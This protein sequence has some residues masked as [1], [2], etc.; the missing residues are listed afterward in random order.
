MMK[1]SSFSGLILV[2][3]IIFFCC[4]Y[5]LITQFEKKELAEGDVIKF[6]EQDKSF[7]ITAIGDIMMHNTQISA[8]FNY[9]EKTYDFAS[10]FTYVKPIF[11]ASD[12][13]IGNLETTLAGETA[14]YSGYPRFNAP[15]VLADDL[16]ASGVDI[17]TTANNHCLDRNFPGISATLDHLDQVGLLHTGTSR[18]QEEQEKILLTEVKGVK[19]AVLAYTYGTNN[20]KV[21]KGK[22]FAVNYIDEKK[23][24]SDIAK[25][26]EQ[27]AKLVIIALHCGQEYQSYPNSLQKQLSQALLEAGADIILGHHPHVLQPADILEVKNEDSCE[28]KFVIYSLGNFISAQRGL[29]RRCSIILNLHMDVDEHGQPYFKEATYIPIYTRRYRNNGHISFEVL[30]LEPVLTS[31]KNGTNP[32]YTKQETD[33]FE[34]S[35]NYVTTHL[36]SEHPCIKMHNLPIPLEGVD[37][38]ETLKI[39]CNETKI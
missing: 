15:E 29:E 4:G 35:F 2:F 14:K 38:L 8:G 24:I 37:L 36:K 19:L 3:F 17:L 7:I 33:I 6:P 23:I 31:I 1:K 22:E 5:T 34:Q 16:K 20:I 30:P 11:Q 32:N 10:F 9:Q 27:G 12:L 13:V 39:R 26:K 18:T 28:N 21:E 25:A